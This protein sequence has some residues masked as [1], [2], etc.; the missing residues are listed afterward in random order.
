M[1]SASARGSTRTISAE[2]NARIAGVLSS[3][4]IRSKL[5][6]STAW[7][8]MKSPRHTHQHVYMVD[9]LHPVGFLGCFD[10]IDMSNLS[11]LDLELSMTLLMHMLL[12]AINFGYKH[13]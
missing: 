5:P 1:R 12:I 2:E 4:Q 9:Q 6:I 3:Y 8:I 13:L 10:K 7:M 11:L